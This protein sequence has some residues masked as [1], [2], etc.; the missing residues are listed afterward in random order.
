MLLVS[1]AFVGD[2]FFRSL[3]GVDMKVGDPGRMLEAVEMLRQRRDD[4]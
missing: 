3:C 2:Q 1:L 4:D